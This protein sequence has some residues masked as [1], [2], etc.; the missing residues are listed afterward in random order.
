MKIAVNAMIFALTIHMVHAESETEIDIVLSRID[1][2]AL[3]P[4]VSRAFKE[5]VEDPAPRIYGLMRRIEIPSD[6]KSLGVLDPAIGKTNKDFLYPQIDGLLLDRK[7]QH[8]DGI[9]AARVVNFF[10]GGATRI[11]YW[12]RS[13]GAQEMVKTVWQRK[14]PPGID[15]SAPLDDWVGPKSAKLKSSEECKLL[16]PFFDD[17]MPP[18]TLNVFAHQFTSDDEYLVEMVTSSEGKLKYN[19]AVRSPRHSGLIEALAFRKIWDQIGD[20][21]TEGGETSGDLPMKQ[22]KT[23]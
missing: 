17:P 11:V 18:S 14:Y 7:V 16:I 6:S 10:H 3:D 22:N 21:P 9:I 12:R 23:R 2:K 13:I 1:Q 15:F 8:P 5:M 19:W 4:E 20:I